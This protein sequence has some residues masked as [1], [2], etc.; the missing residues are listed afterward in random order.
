MTPK[1]FCQMLN[2]DTNRI[3][4][5]VSRSKVEDIQAAIG[6]AADMWDTKTIIVS[7]AKKGAK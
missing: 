4:R 3:A 5:S 2:R 7:P 1:S 6:Y